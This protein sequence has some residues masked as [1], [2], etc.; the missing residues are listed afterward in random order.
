VSV[1]YVKPEP[2]P[3][4]VWVLASQSP[5]AG[6]TI[7]VTQPQFGHFVTRELAEQK[8]DQLHDSVRKLLTPIQI[9]V[10]GPEEVH[11]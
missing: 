2:L 10:T 7:F 5:V 11:P 9:R 8:R 6:K 1:Q 4:Q 3:D